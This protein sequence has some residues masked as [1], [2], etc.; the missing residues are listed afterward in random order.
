MNER[1]RRLTVDELRTLRDGSA[2]ELAGFFD[3][4]E[5]GEWFVLSF[6]SRGRDSMNN[7]IRNLTHRL[8]G[9]YAS[10]LRQGKGGLLSYGFLE[11]TQGVPYNKLVIGRSE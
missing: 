6:S 3:S 8:P 1:Q 4:L 5:P 10:E 11:P 2:P 9:K 7:Y